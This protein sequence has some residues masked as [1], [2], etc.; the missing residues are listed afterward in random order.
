MRWSF[1]DKI[2]D[3][4][5]NKEITA[6][7]IFN[8]DNEVF[9]DHFPSCPIVP[10][11]LLLEA[12]AQ[13]GGRLISISKHHESYGKSV[14]FPVM[15]IIEKASFKKAVKPDEEIIINAKIINLHKSDAKI[16]GK[17][18]L[19][20]NKLAV[21]ANIIYSIFYF[22]QFK[23][24]D[25]LFNASERADMQTINDNIADYFKKNKNS[26]IKFKD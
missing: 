16:C 20:K 12:I 6:V 8:S 1:Y 2:T 9:K 15:T 17:I 5:Y 19:N 3:I 25:S 22:D 18:Y 10:G 21:K 11:V 26:F 4:K 7:K 24:L 23:G 13:A 14:V